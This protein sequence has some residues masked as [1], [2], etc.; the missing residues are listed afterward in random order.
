MGVFN[1]QPAGAGKEQTMTPLD[2]FS[3]TTRDLNRAYSAAND[4]GQG[5]APLEINS[6]RLVREA[7]TTSDVDVYEDEDGLIVLVGTDGTGS[8]ESY[9]AVRPR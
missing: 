8:V 7:E 3:M 5:F 9:W 4:A 1:G 6:W 2:L